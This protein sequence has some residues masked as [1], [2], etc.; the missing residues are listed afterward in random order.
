MTSE[1]STARTPAASRR[2]AAGGG[3][4]FVSPK[5]VRVAPAV[6]PASALATAS[7]TPRSTAVGEIDVGQGAEHERRG[8]P[9]ERAAAVAEELRHEARVRAG[10]D[11]AGGVPVVLDDTPDEPVNRVG[12]REEAIAMSSESGRSVN[13]QALERTRKPSLPARS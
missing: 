6:R 10:E 4:P 1:R 11:V 2:D 13:A 8:L 5:R 9:G 3:P 12:S 7:A